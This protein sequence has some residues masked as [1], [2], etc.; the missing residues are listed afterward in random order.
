[1]SNK[2]PAIQFYPGDW[3]KNVLPLAMEERGVLFEILLIMHNSPSRGKFIIQAGIPY[4]L[5]DLSFI[6]HTNQAKIKQIISKILALD[7]LK[8]EP[9]TKIIF[10]L[11]MLREENLRK[12]RSQCGKL[13]G[14]PKNNTNASKNQVKSTPSSSS[15]SSSS[16]I[17]EKEITK[18]KETNGLYF[19]DSND[20]SRECRETLAMH[21][22]LEEEGEGEV[23]ESNTKR[24]AISATELSSENSN[25][26]LPPSCDGSKENFE[27]F[28]NAYPKRNGKRVGKKE[29]SDFFRHLKPVDQPLAIQ[30][31]KN[32][33]ASSQAKE[34]YA[35]D[36]V[37]FLKKEFFRDWLEKEPVGQ[38]RLV[39]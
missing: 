3:Y 31:A 4:P 20:A 30:A 18:E 2:L 8:Q 26:A 35:K 24:K 33:A 9:D 38:R 29:T 16:L 37:R 32:Y 13:G 21:S 1:M 36:P 10:C 5:E 25:G 14:A 11:R 39:V 19:E 22:R 27:L 34:N 23:K 7:I 15:S 28:W 6:C 17:K 12:I